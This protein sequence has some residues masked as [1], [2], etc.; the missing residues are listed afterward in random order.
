V[1]FIFHSQRINEKRFSSEKEGVRK[2]K[3]LLALVI[4]F[5]FVGVGSLYGQPLKR[6][7]LEIG[8]EISYFTYK[9][10]GVMRERGLKYGIAGSYAYHNKI[11]L[12]VEAKGSY[13]WLDYVGST[14]GGTRLTL[15]NIPDYMLEFRAL[16]GY[17]FYLLNKSFA[18]TPYI[19]I[20]YR[21]LNDNSHRKY[22][23]GYER[24][25]NY[26]YSPIGFEFNIG[27]GNKWFIKE[28][29]EFDY[30]WWGKQ[31]S[32]LS[33]ADPGLND[34]SNRQ[35]QGYGLRGSLALRKQFK[36]VSFEFGP[37]IKYWN[38]K[39]STKEIL[40]FYGVPVDFAYEPRNNSTEIGIMLVFRF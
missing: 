38:I 11:M 10:P 23:G 37:F 24:K 3:K 32:Y 7:T 35:K 40:T 9:E 22:T 4:C 19:G 28:I 14:W 34:P 8:P 39:K 12:K 18:M 13:G 26:V 20:G 27:L 33:N 29:M 31:K 6:H 30:F 16:G 5:T 36:I 15:N 25:S 2:M 21:Y 17:D 1:A